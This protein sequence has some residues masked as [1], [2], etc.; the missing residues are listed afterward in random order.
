MPIRT[1][2]IV[3]LALSTLPF[4]LAC[5]WTVFDDIADGASVRVY[6]APSGYGK[7]QYGAVLSTVHMGEG[8]DA[9][10]HIVASAG[11]DSPVVFEGVWENDG[12]GGSSSTLCKEKKNCAKGVS[13]GS[14]LITFD[15]WATQSE[16]PKQGC[17]LSPGV[18]NAYVFCRSDSGGSENYPLDLAAV[19]EVKTTVHFAGVGLPPNYPLG[20]ALI[21]AHARL[22]T[23]KAPL[24]GTLYFQRDRTSRTQ[25]PP[26]LRFDLIDPRTKKPFASGG[27]EAGDYGYQVAVHESEG[28]SI[29][30]AVAQPSKN[31]VIVA[32]YDPSIEVPASITSEVAQAS[33]RTQTLACVKS[34]DASLVGFGKVLALGDIN[35]DGE[36]ELFAGIDPV[37]Q[38]NGTKQRL[39]M[40]R[41]TG[42]PAHDADA[43]SCALWDEEPV[44]VGCIGGIRGVDCADSA[45]G[46]SVAVGDV[47]GDM[48]NDL[49]VGAPLADVQGEKDAGVVWLIP[50][51]ADNAETG[52]LDFDGM[53]NL[54]ATGQEAGSRL[55]ATVG[56]IRSRG[57]MEPVAGAPGADRVYV[58]MC[59][60]L[61]SESTKSYCLP[62][63]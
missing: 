6:E 47:D 59:S 56:A 29:L 20:V 54:Y 5:N 24:H 53:T 4:A 40:Y 37:D 55:G 10:S 27:E 21:S 13:V 18:P 33:F 12:V 26:N 23:T 19:E 3:S 1:T 15:L 8:D 36:P 62:K 32:R 42:L 35:D 9:S 39:Y 57:R 43:D 28:D 2:R 11:A 17:V 48:F 22:N 41:G 45:F 46:A 30:I 50:G 34:P 63:N 16:T 51:G 7:S 25:V 58:F 52:G 49:I 14:A 44:Q 31:R 61:E 60:T 38:K